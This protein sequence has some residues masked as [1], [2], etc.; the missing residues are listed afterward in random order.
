MIFDTIY[1]LGSRCQNA[2]ILKKYGYRD[3][4]GIFDYLNTQNVKRILHIL[5]D[6]F[7]ELLNPKNNIRSALDEKRVRTLNKY[8]DNIKDF[9]SA[10]LCHHDITNKEQ[11]SAI[12][13]RKERFKKLKNF[14]TLY[15]YTFN[16]W[17]NNVTKEE[18]EKMVDIIKDK[19]DNKN[20]R[21][22]FI[23]LCL[24]KQQGFT[25]IIENEYYDVFNLTIL[26]N[27]YCGGEFKNQKDCQN[28]MD[29]ILSYN[30]KEER[31]TAEKIDLL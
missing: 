28:F 15:N 9:H 16:S 13:R 18:M 5:E 22:N 12:L 7:N 1:S 21:I 2:L 25:K 4:S 20:F 30:I 11:Y 23:S 19:Y 14:N 3:F 24:G 6:D 17:E 8:Y 27:S 26:P 29:I 10:T 31:L